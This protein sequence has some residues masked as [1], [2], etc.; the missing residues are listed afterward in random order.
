MTAKVRKVHYWWVTR[1]GVVTT[2]CGRDPK[3]V[4]VAKGDE[5]VTCAKCKRYLSERLAR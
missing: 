5:K 1:A 3:G 2:G 4:R